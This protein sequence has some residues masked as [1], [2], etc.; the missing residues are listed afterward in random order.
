MKTLFVHCGLLKTATTTIQHWCWDHRDEL[1]AQGVCMLDARAAT[2]RGFP[3][4]RNGHFL[5]GGGTVFEERRNCEMRNVK[6][7][8][9]GLDLVERAFADCDRVL[10]SD[11]SLFATTAAGRTAFWE[12]LMRH[13]RR[14]GY[15]VRPIV[16]L[17]RQD[18]LAMSWYSQ[19]VKTCLWHWGKM[20]FGDWLRRLG[21]NQLDFRVGLDVIAAHVG[22]D[23]I[24]VRS[25]DRAVAREGV[26]A[27]FL[28]TIGVDADG[29]DA[30]GARARN[31][32]LA[33]PV[34]TVKSWVNRSPWFSPSF[35]KIL[36]DAA[37]ESSARVTGPASALLSPGECREII[38]N[39]VEANAQ[40][41]RRF[42]P[43]GG[44]LFDDDVA[45]TPAFDPASPQLA[46]CAADYFCTL[47]RLEGA[48]WGGPLHAHLTV[49]SPVTVS[50]GLRRVRATPRRCAAR[51]CSSAI[52]SADG[53]RILPAAGRLSPWTASASRRRFA[54][55]SLWS[56]RWMH[57]RLLASSRPRRPPVFPPASAPVHRGSPICTIR[58]ISPR[59]TPRA[60]LRAAPPAFPMPCPDVLRYTP[61][62]RIGV[63][64]ARDIP[65]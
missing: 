63:P 52:S 51:A 31:L 60:A 48:P 55:S 10:V 22:E 62:P 12:P 54:R 59:A 14:V 37:V 33:P 38:G 42:L 11:E 28:A 26:M 21:P 27:D 1:R 32:G 58:Y 53:R 4:V 47:A 45:D 46:A 3:R 6:R 5:L 34:I 23:N 24:I 56:H 25:F 13:A 2:V 57:V 61:H 20:D 40:V 35:R 16:Y 9:R 19:D 39:Y 49:L 8:E 18:R 29:M 64:P 36:R 43:A 17:R 41:A 15:V 7:L 30:E 50:M 65:R 44:A